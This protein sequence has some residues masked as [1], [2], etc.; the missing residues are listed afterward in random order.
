MNGTM[1]ITYFRLSDAKWT[2]TFKPVPNLLGVQISNVP[3]TGEEP[4]ILYRNGY[5][6]LQLVRFNDTA[7]IYNITAEYEGVWDFDLVCSPDSVAISYLDSIE[8]EAIIQDVYHIDIGSETSGFS[9]II[10]IDRMEYL[11]S[12]LL[13]YHNST[14][15]FT[16]I[17]SASG[18]PTYFEISD[19]GVTNRSLDSKTTSSNCYMPKVD[20]GLIPLLLTT[21]SIGYSQTSLVSITWIGCPHDTER[22]IAYYPRAASDLALPIYLLPITILGAI[23]V[24]FLL[25]SKSSRVSQFIHQNHFKSRVN[26][27]KTSFVS[28]IIDKAARYRV[29]FLNP[30]YLGFNII[31]SIVIFHLIM[32][33]P[34]IG[35]FLSLTLHGFGSI[36]FLD[37]T[38]LLIS[39]T[40]TC[41][42]LIYL[43]DL[44]KPLKLLKWLIWLVVFFCS[45]LTFVGFTIGGLFIVLTLSLWIPLWLFTDLEVTH[46]RWHQLL[47]AANDTLSRIKLGSEN[48]QPISVINRILECLSSKNILFLNEVLTD[49]L[50]FSDN[51]NV[52]LESVNDGL[53]NLKTH[54]SLND[55]KE[56]LDM[57]T[58][59]DEFMQ[60]KNQNETS[61][62]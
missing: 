40:I 4:Y 54:K 35:T 19:R 10:E 8:N 22:V 31:L 60:N 50:L 52:I 27:I 34:Y 1:G 18:N 20:L 49:D 48:R 58:E 11:R 53:S 33:L 3:S 38:S 57:I 7:I 29:F 61:K 23:I 39:L 14:D 55:D 59:F 6:N 56:F 13:S 15:T 37:P 28:L 5:K 32:Q 51:L 43:V 30:I 9:S 25:V 62:F 41:A 12:V 45:I 36:N 16:A 17:L 2:S 42:F 24:I 44:K 46:T 47:I 21:S 26:K